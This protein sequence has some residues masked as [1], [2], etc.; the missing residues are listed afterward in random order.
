MPGELLLLLRAWVATISLLVVLPWAAVRMV[1]GLIESDLSRPRA[2]RERTRQSVDAESVTT[3][4]HETAEG[5][6][7]D[8]AVRPSIPLDEDADGSRADPSR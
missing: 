6:S 2:Y 1:V 3:L 5:E 4:S 8:D 7:P